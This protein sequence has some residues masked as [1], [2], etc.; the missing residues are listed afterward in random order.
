MPLVEFELTTPVLERTK[1]IR[2][3]DYAGTVIN[4]FMQYKY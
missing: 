3:L 2:S 1:T 4:V